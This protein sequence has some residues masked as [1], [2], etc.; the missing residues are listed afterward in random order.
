MDLFQYLSTKIPPLLKSLVIMFDSLFA[1]PIFSLPQE[2]EPV[3]PH[4]PDEL[5]SYAAFFDI[6]LKLNPFL[7]PIF[8]YAFYE[9][10]L[11]QGIK[12]VEHEGN[13]YFYNKITNQSSYESPMDHLLHKFL[14]LVSS[15]KTVFLE[16]VS[17]L[18]ESLVNSSLPELSEWFGPIHA[19]SE[20]REYYYNKKQMISSWTHP[21]S[22]LL[23]NANELLNLSRLLSDM[24]D[25]YLWPTI[26]RL[27]AQ[28]NLA[29]KSED[30]P[31][32]PREET[33]S[34]DNDP[35]SFQNTPIKQIRKTSIPKVPGISLAQHFSAAVEVF[36][37]A[38]PR[39]RGSFSPELSPQFGSDKQRPF[40]H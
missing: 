19:E 16:K 13:V 3:G 23:W 31:T 37:M 28:V 1:F 18:M 39:R 29:V 5:S 8:A 12:R 34:D 7:I 33:S 36:S 22:I 2:E 24:A 21:G 30:V 25:K 17:E 14:P 15:Q 9:N 27:T 40:S 38:T 6:D 26:S 35:P 11:P 20:G 10:P 4:V 32:S